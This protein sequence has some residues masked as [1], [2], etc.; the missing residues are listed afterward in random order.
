VEL[1]RIIASEIQQVKYEDEDL[2]M[3]LQYGRIAFWR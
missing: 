3:M 2:V 1:E